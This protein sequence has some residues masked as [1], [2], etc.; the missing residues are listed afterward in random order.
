MNISWSKYESYITCS[1]KYHLKYQRKVRIRPPVMRFVVGLVTHKVLEDWVRAG[2]QEGFVAKHIPSIFQEY[3]R[4]IKFKSK[5]QYNDLFK[6]ALKASLTSQAVYDALGIPKH[7]TSVEP[8]LKIPMGNNNYLIGGWD[9]LDKDAKAIYD[10]KTMKSLQGNVLQLET[11]VVAANKSGY[12]V[13]RMGFITPL[14]S[15]KVHSFDVDMERIVKHENDLLDALDAMRKGVQPVA[16]PGSHCN[17]CDYNKTSNCPATYV[18]S[19]APRR[20][21]PTKPKT[22]RKVTFNRKS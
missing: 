16:T 4:N 11:Y 19:P 10:M 5:E 8:R 7:S 6:K 17:W 9:V 3:V 21:T 15:K 2:C 20:R 14:Q 1:L 12:E 13:D 22:T 18:P